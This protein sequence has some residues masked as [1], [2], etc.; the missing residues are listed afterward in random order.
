MSTTTVNYCISLALL[1]PNSSVGSAEYIFHTTD[2]NTQCCA[3]A[4]ADLS[5]SVQPLSVFC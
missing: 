4:K 1:Y 3:S 5:K 2:A